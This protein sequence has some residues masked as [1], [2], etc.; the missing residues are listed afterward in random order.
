MRHRAG[1]KSDDFKKDAAKGLNLTLE[2]QSGEMSG[3]K[4]SIFLSG[5]LTVGAGCGTW[6]GSL[7]AGD[8]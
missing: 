2:R 1:S 8:T 5:H 7:R 4:M 3:V 6:N